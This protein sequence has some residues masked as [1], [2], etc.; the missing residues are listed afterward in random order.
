VAA[1]ERIV[2]APRRK[3]N[4]RARAKK[5]SRS[6]VRIT[7]AAML[8]SLLLGMGLGLWVYR[9]FASD[10]PSNLDAITDYRPLRASQVLSASGELIGEFF[11]EKRVLMPIERMPETVR[12]AFIAAEDERF[13]SHGG[14]DYLGILRA[15]WAN[16]RAGSVVQG[17]ST[18]TQQVAKLLIVGTERSLARKVREAMLAYRI[19]GRLTKNQIL[20][21]YLNHVY[22]GHGAYGVAAA[23]S[24]YFG[25]NVE[26]LSLA[27]A[28]MLAAMPKAPGRA[29]PFRDF[30]RARARQHYVLDQMTQLG[31][32]SQLQADAA[33]REPLV[34]VS[35]GRALKN[36][37]APYFVETVRKYVADKYGD[38]ELLQR[39]LRIHTTLDT[40]LQRAAE[41][42]VRA[43][44]EDLERRLGFSGPLASLGPEQRRR[45]AVGAPR[46]FG[47]AGFSLE[48]DEQSGLLVAPPDLR[49]ATVDATRPGALLPEHAG[50]SLA[51]DA[52][53][54]S[55]K[56]RRPNPALAAPPEIDPDTVY[57]AMVTA[58]AKDRVSLASGSLRAELEPEDV[59]RVLAWSGE[60][61]T[62]IRPGDVLP[63]LFAL[64]EAASP[65]RKAGR[66][67][68][69]PPLRARL[70]ARP[71]VQG[72]LVALHPRTGHLMAMVG[73]Y[74]YDKS[75]FNRAVQA[76]RQVGSAIKPFI[77]AA[78][79]DAGLTPLT[80][81]WDVPVKFRTASGLW[82]PKNYKPQYLGPVT[83]H[84]ALARSINTV[85]AQLAAQVGVDRV[86]EL[87]RKAGVKS[88]LPR[89]LSLALG[90]ADLG[91]QELAYALASFANQGRRV[92]PLSILR[93]IDAE[94]VV[95][96]DHRGKLESSAVISAETAFIV[97]DMLKAV[98]ESGTARKAQSLGRPIAGK[99]GTSTNYRD[100]WFFGFVP[101]VLAAVWVG[102]DDFKT[103][104]HDVTGGQAALPIWMDFM[105]EAFASRPIADFEP[106][107]GT[108]FVRAD[109]E[110][111]VPATPS[112]P[113]SRL[114][115]FRRGTL[116]PAFRG[117]SHAGAFSDPRF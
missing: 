92:D 51:L 111:G 76:R 109:P 71:T 19:E 69:P 5:F 110:K 32:V 74:D 38:E 13:F 1:H 22:L 49:V 95:L 65:V 56:A 37:A 66:K 117:P 24:A 114:V 33:R 41:R 85:A 93:I 99:T 102:R 116:P 60:G 40:R 35:R 64:P 3:T 16:L 63:V 78:A 2:T 9:Q 52:A 39:G 59:A 103:V 105:S 6:L 106:P 91:L 18:I 29:T 86:V 42:A 15:A 96:E 43:G 72:A 26:D 107:P 36:V 77:Y 90:T 12:Q 20:G 108:L 67:T 94:G 84:T 113:K 89:A 101:D 48:D 25:K 79:I 11:V 44:L 34:L 73:G 31:L 61:G 115:P 58:L 62:G 53:F 50:R 10:L 8:G 23:S 75:Q 88:K 100:A 104:G 4:F 27:E 45:L 87:L 21:I 70:S 47:P 54:L 68:G 98:T 28:A 30:E 80:I 7:L 14:V 81:R 57:A 55:R 46:P 83:L 17:G 112:N 82:A 97:T